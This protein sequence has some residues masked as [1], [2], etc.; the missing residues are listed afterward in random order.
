[1]RRTLEKP[2]PPSDPPIQWCEAGGHRLSYSIEGDAEAP[3][4]ILVHGVPGSVA[5][6]RYLAPVLVPNFRVVRLEFPGFGSN[7]AVPTT[8]Y[9]SSPEARADLIIACADALG[10][11]RWTMLGH[12]MGGPPAM[13]AAARAPD[14]VT[15]LGLIA[16]LG[17]RRHRGMVVPPWAMKLNLAALRVPG[18]SQ[19]LVKTSRR[20]YARLGFA[21]GAAQLTRTDL[22][23]HGQIIGAIKF[24]QL[25]QVPAQVRCPVW[26]IAAVD[27]RLVEPEIPRELSEKFAH[28]TLKM[29][30]SGG[31]NIQKSRARAIAEL[32]TRT[33]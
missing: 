28:A 14:R 1:M 27:D 23:V 13:C 26:V 22:E 16:S 25:Q 2:V 12:S 32:I 18:L 15:A 6:F 3:V 9:P 30:P 11:D 24:S 4:V 19:L 10:I 29:F 33:A 21:K 5:D 17:L 31:H 8:N 7:R 20:A